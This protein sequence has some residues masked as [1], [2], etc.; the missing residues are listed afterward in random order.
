MLQVELEM[1]QLQEQVTLVTVVEV[2][3]DQLTIH[4]EELEDQV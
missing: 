4:Q 2:E 3:E 1:F